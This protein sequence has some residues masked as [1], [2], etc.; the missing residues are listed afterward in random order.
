MLK[1]AITWAERLL[2]GIASLALLASVGLAFYAVI[3]RYGYNAS[4]EWLEEAS[5]YLALF[6]ALLVAGPVLRLRGHVALDLVPS[7]LP[8]RGHHIHRFVTGLI[9]FA[10][11]AGAFWWGFQLMSQS[12]AFGMRTGSLQFPQWLPY[13]II[14]IG[15][16]V[17]IL[18]SLVEMIEAGADLRRN[19]P[20]R[21]E[22][23]GGGA[24]N[25][26]AP[27]TGPKAG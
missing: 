25:T 24:T 21:D 20:P 27:R 12:I 19:A 7:A 9:A 26:P 4:L 6:S 13:S 22:G 23:P 8:G 3:L 14:P 17:L 16:A 10:V 5:R 2:F 11:G 18:F 1:F 15:M